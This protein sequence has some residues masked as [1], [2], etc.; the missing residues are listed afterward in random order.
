MRHVKATSGNPAAAVSNA[1]VRDVSLTVVTK[2]GAEEGAFRTDKISYRSSKDAGKSVERPP[3]VERIAFRKVVNG[4]I[5]VM[6]RLGNRR[7]RVRDFS[8]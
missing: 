6:T 5:G 2:D 1:V 8:L 3:G 7:V 4:R